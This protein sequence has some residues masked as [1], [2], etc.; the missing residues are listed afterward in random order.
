LLK[1]HQYSRKA[2]YILF[3]ADYTVRQEWWQKSPISRYVEVAR[4][5]VWNITHDDENEP[6]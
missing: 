4:S 3:L 2:D 6:I 1:R 5:I